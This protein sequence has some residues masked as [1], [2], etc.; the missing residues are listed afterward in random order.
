MVEGSAV[1]EGVV[2]TALP[3]A[4]HV[5]LGYTR[6]DQV[7]AIVDNCRANPSTDGTATAAHTAT[8]TISTRRA[9]AGRRKEGSGP[10]APGG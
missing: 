7:V 8:A 6:L 9:R 4:D 10:V 5:L 3:V 2:H 1:G